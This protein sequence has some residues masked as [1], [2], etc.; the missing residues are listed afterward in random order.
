MFKGVRF[1]DTRLKGACVVKE[2]L[3]DFCWPNGLLLFL[4]SCAVHLELQGDAA[5]G[6]DD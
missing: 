4:S 5:I 1:P 6:S 3:C 2:L